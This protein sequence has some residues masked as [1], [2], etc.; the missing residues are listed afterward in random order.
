M[1]FPVLRLP[2]WIRLLATLANAEAETV[3]AE[4]ERLSGLRRE[5]ETLRAN[6]QGLGD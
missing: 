3:A 6:L 1:R 5:A 4:R 2:F